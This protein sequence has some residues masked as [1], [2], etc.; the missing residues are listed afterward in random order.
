MR[1]KRTPYPS[2]KKCFA[3]GLF[4]TRDRR[5]M[6]LHYNECDAYQIHISARRVEQEQ[7]ENDVA[8]DALYI[9]LPDTLQ[10][11]E[12]WDFCEAIVERTK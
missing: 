4:E 1:K 2:L 5:A 6:S 10:T 3:C 12:M 7:L 9:K 8:I 11:S